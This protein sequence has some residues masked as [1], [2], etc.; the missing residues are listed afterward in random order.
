MKF[1]PSA[2]GPSLMCS[3][4]GVLLR[5]EEDWIKPTPPTNQTLE[6][7]HEGGT[8]LLVLRESGI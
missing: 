4:K 8:R 2:T 7:K 6:T 5:S 3:L 1:I